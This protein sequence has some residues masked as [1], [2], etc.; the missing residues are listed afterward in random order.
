MSPA[1]LAVLALVVT[2]PVAVLVACTAGDAIVYPQQAATG[3]G[4]T[5]DDAGRIIV[6]SGIPPKPVVNDGAVLRPPNPNPISCAS[7]GLDSDGGCD[8]TAGMGCCLPASNTSGDPTNNKCDEQVQFFES[9]EF[10]HAANDIFLSC[11]GSNT[12]STCCW[13]PNATGAYHSRY[14]AACDSVGFEACDP[15]VDGGGTCSS[16]AACTHVMCRGVLI[17]YCGGVSPCP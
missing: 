15:D 3:E 14:R 6:D 9:N 5:P 11:L 7:T 17:G 10:C 16:G 1:R 8:P 4:G 2:L 12:D 13:E